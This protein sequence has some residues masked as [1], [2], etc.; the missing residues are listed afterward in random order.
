MSHDD[1]VGYGR[2]PQHT[3][4]RKGQSGNP[5]GR[6][7]GTRNLATDLAD[8]LQEK[9]VVKEG[10]V[11]RRISKQRAVIKRLFERALQG[12]PKSI[13]VLFALTRDHVPSDMRDAISVFPAED[14]AILEHYVERVTRETIVKGSDRA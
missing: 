7:K 13:A 11:A 12:D 3:Q 4:F 2:P 1:T 8:E 14:R 6:P 9:I 5:K 10:G